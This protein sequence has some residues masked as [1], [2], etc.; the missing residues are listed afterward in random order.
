LFFF[1]FF[2]F[3][4]EFGVLI[5]EGFYFGACLLLAEEAAAA[6]FVDLAVELFYLLL[7]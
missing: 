2:E 4:E 3:V 6:L 1:V 5:D 7:V